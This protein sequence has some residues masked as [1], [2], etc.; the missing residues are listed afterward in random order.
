MTQNHKNEKQKAQDGLIFGWGDDPTFLSL[1]VHSRGL[2]SWESV[3]RLF[4]IASRSGWVWGCLVAILMERSCFKR[5]AFLRNGHEKLRYHKLP[6]V[7]RDD[8]L[9]KWPCGCKVG[10]WTAES[11][12]V[13]SSIRKSF[14]HSTQSHTA[15]ALRH[16]I[17]KKDL[18]LVRWRRLF[19][20]WTELTQFNLT[21][22][23]AFRAG[24]TFH[25]VIAS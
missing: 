10:C 1:T 11:I 18:I 2:Q 3:R 5:P 12:A 25:N 7:Q 23:S 14:G 24:C 20:L 19:W 21:L 6:T 13:K 15:T 17:P 16:W 22:C 8:L 4:L 9:C